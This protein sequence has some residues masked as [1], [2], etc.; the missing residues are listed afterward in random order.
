M[1]ILTAPARVF[2]PATRAASGTCRWVLRPEPGKVG[3][4]AINGTHYVFEVLT[5][6]GRTVGYRLTKQ[7]GTVY[8][9]DVNQPHGWS[10]DCPD[11]TYHPER[12]SGCKHQVAVKAALRQLEPAAPADHWFPAA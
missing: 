5:D 11:G 4:L 10:C 8:D 2:K 9:L 7:D 6:A 1:T 3:I 12:P